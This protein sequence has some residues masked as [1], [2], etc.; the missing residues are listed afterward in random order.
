MD[1]NSL[2]KLHSVELEIL[3]KF[4]SLCEQ[5]SIRYFIIGGTLIGAVRHGGFIP[6]DDDID[7]AM[8]RSDYNRLID[9]M[10]NLEDDVLGMEYYKDNPDLYFYP[11]RITNKQYK[12]KEPRTKDGYAHPWMDILPI[13]G[14]PNGKIGKK[15]FRAK[16]DLYR[17][18][19]GLHYV[20]N[21]RDVQRSKLQRVI[22][23][24]GKAT[25]VGKIIDPT[26]VKDRIT[27]TLSANSMENCDISGTCMGA[28]YIHEFTKTEHFGS[29]IDV[30][31]EG[32][33]VRAPEMIDEYLT[34]MYGDYMK[35]P[36]EEERLAHR[37]EFINY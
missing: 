25:K 5:N 28:Y 22:I 16:M 31:F 30:A 29:G 2:S 26:K 18:L 24:F 4:V 27:K 10:H 35:M 13:D 12:I 37:V 9:V 21:L 33:T 3:E 20:D 14:M 7:I 6:W 32:L 1:N 36:P 15:L 34:H 11:I 17:L 19:L 8:P 23:A